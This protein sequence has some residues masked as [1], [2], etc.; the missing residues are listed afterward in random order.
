VTFFDSV[1]E[2][3]RQGFRPCK[4]CRPTTGAWTSPE[5][6]PETFLSLLAPPDGFVPEVEVVVSRVSTPLGI[7]V[8]GATDEGIGLLEFSD[9][10][11]LA[12]QIGRLRRRLRCAFRP[13]ESSLT[14]AL[15][16]EL[17]E[18]FEGRRRAF[19][20]PLVLP[21]SVFQRLVWGE[22]RAIPY[23]ETLSYRQLAARVGRPGAVRATGRANGD[24]RVAILVPCHRVIGADGALRGYGGKLW[25][26]RRLLEMEGAM[27]PSAAQAALPYA[28]DSTASSQSVRSPR[29]TAR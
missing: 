4:R 29:F 21:G 3:E 28:P 27:R 13:G 19:D 7:M 17:Q 9:R 14:A 6:L 8:A 15:R 16:S 20:V 11:M 18:Y 26:K 23:G 24:N 2:A 5:W 25:R 22:L 1:A 10:R 12:T